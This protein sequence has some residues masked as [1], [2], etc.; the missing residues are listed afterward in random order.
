MTQTLTLTNVG[1][2]KE[3]ALEIPEKGGIT[4]LKGRNGS[5]KTTALEAVESAI[6]GKGQLSV[7]DGALNGKVDAFGVT[8][9]VG[10]STRRKGELEV[11]SLDGKLS[12]SELIDP[13]L[14]S[15]DAAD[16]RR[17]KA[18]CALAGAKP[19]AELFHGLVGGKDIF[20]LIVSLATAKADDLV[21]MAE[22]IKRD[23]EAEARREEDAAEKAEGQAL[24]A[25]NAAAGID[26]AGPC[27]SKQ[28]QGE[29]EAAITQEAA[30]KAAQE[31]HDKA[32]RTAEVARAKLAEQEK[33]YA[34]MGLDE[35]KECEATTA[36]KVTA[37]EADVRAAEDVWRKAKAALDTAKVSHVHAITDRKNAEQHESLIGQWREQIAASIPFA[38]LPGVLTQA[39]E[40]VTTA[41]K[42]VE[43]GA[44]IRQAKQHLAYCNKAMERSVIHRTKAAML[45]EAAKGT[46]EVLSGVV[47]KLGTPLRVEAGRLVLDTKRG[48]TYF[49]DL[50][51]G[52]RSK[53]A[54]DIGIDAVGANGV[55]TLSQEIF[56]G[57]DPSN[58]AMLAKH[59]ES[60]EVVILTAEASDDEEIT[61]EVYE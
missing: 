40:N 52:E 38:P 25:K 30:S 56:E 2:I 49:D 47:G 9:T 35:A 57:L 10:R 41:R 54:V 27:D 58:R 46:D 60:R 36:A 37:L 4:V 15:P 17:I 11:H 55:L 3:L 43:Q 24:G 5:G 32:T 45:R 18:L 39:A 48:N 42:A 6:T 8:I 16:A 28:L 22:R 14:K 19:D 12:I 7:R 50:S 13:G 29:L 1:P 61:A 53:I 20:E 26:V 23:L 59:A 21:I 44:L 34:G 51:A 31:A 33:E